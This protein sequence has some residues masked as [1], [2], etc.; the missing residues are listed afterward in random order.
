MTYKVKIAKHPDY[1][2]NYEWLD[3]DPKLDRLQFDD[4]TADVLPMFYA[5]VQAGIIAMQVSA[6]KGD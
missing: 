6:N 2:Q 4:V 1:L 3:T 5:L